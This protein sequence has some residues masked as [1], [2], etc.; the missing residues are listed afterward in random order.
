M[1]ITNKGEFQQIVFDQPSDNDFQ[2]FMNIY[3]KCTANHIIFWL[4]TLLLHQIFPDVSEKF[5]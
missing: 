3:K 5:F 2:D 1:N 4:L